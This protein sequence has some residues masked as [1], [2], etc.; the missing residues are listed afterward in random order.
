MRIALI[1]AMTKNRVI[2]AGGG[3]PWHISSDLIHFKEVTMGKPIIMGGKTHRSIGKALPGRDNIVITR[4]PEALAGEAIAARNLD[5]ALELALECTKAR[6][7]DEI[8]VIG[9]GE[10]YDLVMD[11]AD[12]IYLTEVHESV[13]GDVYFPAIDERVWHET[14]REDHSAGVKDSADFS[15]VVLERVRS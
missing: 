14:S 6:H 1:V 5:H 7:V 13:N 2:G 4:S 9:G 10:I 3:M 11:K 12:V 8:M 15:F